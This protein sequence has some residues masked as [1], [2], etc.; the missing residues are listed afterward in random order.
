MI[1]QFEEIRIQALKELLDYDRLY[2]KLHSLPGAGN[3]N[4]TVLVAYQREVLENLAAVRQHPNDVVPL[5]SAKA[6]RISTN[7][8]AAM[9]AV[10]T[11][12]LT[13][14]PLYSL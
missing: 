9:R 13:A 1:P 11:R 3:R 4:H 8:W 10:L 12:K 6:L 2:D 5:I 14:W 7:T